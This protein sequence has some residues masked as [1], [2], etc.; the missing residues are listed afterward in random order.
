[1]IQMRDVR[2][3]YGSLVAVDGLSFEVRQ[4]E[5]FG[6]LGPNGAGK[7]TT[8]HMIAGVLRPDGGGIALDGADDPTRPEVRRRLGIA[9]QALALYDTLSGE[10]NVTFIGR[11]YGL[12]GP[13]LQEAV[14]RA[15]EL[16]GLTA[17][18]KDRAAAYS[19]GMK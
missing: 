14:G 18:R 2:K 15:L 8:L 13:A 9:P 17:R 4:G 16:V 6:L 5:T 1:M 10:E 11:L 19:G 12:R 7:T 3:Q